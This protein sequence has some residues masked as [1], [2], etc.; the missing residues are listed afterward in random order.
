MKYARLIWS[1]LM[2]SKRRTLL[3]L[4]SVAVAFFLFATLA[5][6]LTTLAAVTETG[7]ESRLA[8]RNAIG[9]TFDM[10]QSYHQRLRGTSGVREATHVSWFGGVYVDPKDFFAQLAIDPVVYFE[11]YP[12]ILVPEDQL[13]AFQ[14]ERIAAI[15]GRKLMERFGWRLGQTV[16]LQG[17]IYPGDWEFVIRGVYEAEDPSFGEET[18]YF[19]FDYLYE[20][21]N[22]GARHGWYILELDDPDQAGAVSAQIDAMF[23]NSTAPTKTETERAFQAGFVTMWGNV[24]F[25]VRAIGTA[26]FFAILLIAANTMMMAARERTGEVAVLKTLGFRD[27]QLAGFVIVEALLVSLTG[28][29]LGLMGAKLVFESADPL[30]SFLPGFSV[31]VGTIAAGLGIA[32]LLGLVAGAVPAWQSARLSVVEAL[33]HVG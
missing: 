15:A 33:R 31:A 26:V 24:G 8:T 29:L 25:L 9:I 19:H 11:M 13:R 22:Q 1:N 10:P 27:G 20:L 17:T 14:G 18:F 30:A 3:T 2:R 23:E 16:T 32:A 6:V 5:S 7:S 28:G 12:E 21:S 4:G